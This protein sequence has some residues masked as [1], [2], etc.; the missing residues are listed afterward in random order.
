MN[1]DIDGYQK[2]EK[3][4]KAGKKNDP[5]AF[6]VTIR[7]NRLLGIRHAYTAVTIPPTHSTKP[8]T[9]DSTCVQE[10]PAQIIV[11]DAGLIG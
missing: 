1:T 10:R 11:Q 9:D 8:D 3:K 2:K 7:A 6:T 5:L 4:G